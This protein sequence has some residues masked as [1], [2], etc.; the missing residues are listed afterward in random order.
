MLS[1]LIEI[2]DLYISYTGTKKNF[3]VAIYLNFPGGENAQSTEPILSN[4]F[5]MISTLTTT[6]MDGGVVREWTCSIRAQPRG[7]SV[8]CFGKESIW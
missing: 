7:N 4:G 1:Y 5:S 2:S 8:V 3:L 6:R